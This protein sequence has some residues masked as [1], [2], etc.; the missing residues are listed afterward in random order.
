MTFIAPTAGSYLV[1]VSDVRG[2]SGDNYTYR[3]ILRRPQPDFKV[4]LS[5]QNPAIGAG[6]GKILVAKAER[7]D[8]FNG[9]I[10]V[11]IGS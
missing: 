10:T 1:R 6:S 5:P 3:L 9:P 4:T 2:F 7:I 8:N 11:E